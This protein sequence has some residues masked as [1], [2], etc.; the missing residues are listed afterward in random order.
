MRNAIVK[1]IA[2][3]AIAA[4]TAGAAV[5]A[6]GPV[7]GQGT[8]ET[9]LQARDLDA[10]GTV[11][12]Y[13]DTVLDISWLADADPLGRVDFD[14]ANTWA[15]TLTVA[16]IGG[17]HLPTIHI[18]SCGVH[19]YDLDVFLGGGGICGYGVQTS[20]SDMA[21]MNVVT[22]GNPSYYVP[23]TTPLTNNSGPFT[24]LRTFGYWF[25]RDY[26]V[27]P[28]TLEVNTG[29]A[30]RYS[31]HAGRQDNLAKTWEHHA[32]AVHDGDV[33]A[34]AAPVPEPQ[35]YALMGAGLAMMVLLGRRRRR[36]G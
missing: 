27:D 25:S 13:Y 2:A 6:P 26:A 18:D 24:N 21:H 23:P 7:S 34:I 4:L 28:W 20:T 14:T 17:W 15:T 10:D 36:E 11:D 31:F 33:G 12:A 5:A 3:A 32:W 8:W 29:E 19:G 35:T 30:W 9:T 22:L 16:G 1:S